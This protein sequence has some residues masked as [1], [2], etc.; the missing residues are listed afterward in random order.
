MKRR[1]FIVGSLALGTAWR[2]LAG[3]AHAAAS[4]RFGYAAITWN[5]NDR[6]AIEDVA[7]C[8]YQGIQLRSSA[9]EAFGDRPA[10]LKELL[11][12][13]HLAMVAFSSGNMEIDPA[14]ERENLES[15]LKKARFTRDLGGKFLQLTDAR[16]KRAVVAAD[17]KRMGHLLTELGKR[18]AD[19]G[20]TVSYHNH[21]NNLGER[22]E[23]VR[24]VLES[25]D[26]KFVKFQLDTAH[27]Q[28]GGGNPAAAVREYADR[29]SFLHIKDLEAPVPGATGDTSRSYRFVELGRG[30]V[31]LKAVFAALDAV[32]YKGW[33]VVELDEVPDNART[34]KESALISRAFIEKQLGLK[35]GPPPSSAASD[36]APLFDG[37]SLK[38]WRGYRQPDATRTRWRVENGML[39]VPSNDGQD[40]RGALDLITTETFSDFEL[41]WEWRVAAGGNSG[42][43]YFV[44]EDMDSAIGHEYQLI[45]DERHADAKVG[46]KRQTAAFYDV[47]AAS[48]RALRPAGTFNESRVIATGT[49]VE[50]WLNG[51]RVLQYELETPALQ[52]AVDESKFK[53][54]A[55]F[56]RRQKGHILVQDHGDAVWYRNIRIRRLETRTSL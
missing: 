2:T 20:V 41:A 48:N 4:I 43:K 21:M 25:S 9:L 13:H 5:G 8:G 10:A 11:D 16:P 29:L 39:T 50:H 19:L 36:W 38:G 22:P 6:Q 35:V 23:E 12:R 49:H 32:G 34:P 24:A 26:P 47:L 31:D 28:Q 1:D 45:D 51:T 55:R 30:K 14:A 44:L 7:A 37:V 33:A 27:F 54:I 42:V 40:T 18:T 17:Y 53:G 15:H 3:T 46:P 52:A 56:G